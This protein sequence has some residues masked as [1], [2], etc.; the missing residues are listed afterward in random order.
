[1]ILYVQPLSYCATS[2][3][4]RFLQ[5]NDIEADCDLLHFQDA[6][7]CSRAIRT[8]PELIEID[9]LEEDCNTVMEDLGIDMWARGC[10]VFPDGHQKILTSK[11]K[12]NCYIFLGAVV[13]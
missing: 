9:Q 4:F 5:K 2:P 1:M 8:I 3:Y 10:P 11:V 6:I 13:Q 12:R 7:A